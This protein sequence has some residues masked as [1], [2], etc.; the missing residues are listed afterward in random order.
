MKTY[1]SGS[2][3]RIK[4]LLNGKE[5]YGQTLCKPELRWYF[6]I[7]AAHRG[8]PG[9]L[10]RAIKKYGTENFS[11]EVVLTCTEPLLNTAERW[12]IEENNSLA[13]SGYNLTTG[14]DSGGSQSKLTRRR[15][16]KSMLGR[17]FSEETLKRMSD[18]QKKRFATH[19]MPPCSDELRAM[20]SKRL[21]GVRPSEACVVASVVSNRA[22]L[23]GATLPE[24]HCQAISKGVQRSW[25]SKSEEYR[26]SFGACIVATK[27]E[28]YTPEELAVIA[29]RGVKTRQDRF[30]TEELSA[31]GRKG[32]LATSALYTTKEWSKIAKRNLWTRTKHYG[33]VRTATGQWASAPMKGK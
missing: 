32:G 26:S 2:I 11:A 22:R 6:H 16:R 13:P 31:I 4:N 19:P 14:G 12:F 25:D 15:H 17:Q 30:S 3:Y 29:R 5:Y 18:S 27:K 23:T 10:Q 8:A 9:A 1:R 21:K 28:R 20:R 33:N 7:Y 24:A